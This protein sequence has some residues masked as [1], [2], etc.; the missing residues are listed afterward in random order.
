MGNYRLS[1]T[2][3]IDPRLRHLTNDV[4]NTLN[5]VM[6][7]SS[8]G[9]IHEAADMIKNNVALFDSTAQKIK[10]ESEISMGRHDDNWHVVAEHL[11]SL[12]KNIKE[13]ME[14]GSGT[15]AVPP[16]QYVYMIQR[17]V[18]TLPETVTEYYEHDPA[19]KI[20]MDPISKADR[21]LLNVVKQYNDKSSEILDLT[22]TGKDTDAAKK[23]PEFSVVARHTA[24][25][26]L[27]ELLQGFPDAPRRTRIGWNR[28][29]EK[30]LAEAEEVEN[31]VTPLQIE[32]AKKPVSYTHLTLP[33]ILLV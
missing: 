14:A 1:T 5:D 12:S 22:K 27:S 25:R 30:L 15:D 17:S 19:N 32:E 28:A 3:D 4:N 21:M 16:A 6:A 2:I 20:K 13:S 24:D 31:K 18:K 7:L 8:E 9:R 33:T 29:R 10:E 11:E 26:I 23:L